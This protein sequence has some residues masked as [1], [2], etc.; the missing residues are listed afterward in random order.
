MIARAHFIRWMHQ[1]KSVY[2]VPMVRFSS[3]VTA[4][5]S[6]TD[7]FLR[8]GKCECS[9]FEVRISI[10]RWNFRKKKH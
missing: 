7:N 9:H 5:N 8:Y 4:N 1:S 6:D 10:G 2:I 3:G